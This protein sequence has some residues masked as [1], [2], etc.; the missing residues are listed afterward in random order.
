MT[1]IYVS[2][3]TFWLLSNDFIYWDTKKERFAI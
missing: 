2:P 1:A 3:I